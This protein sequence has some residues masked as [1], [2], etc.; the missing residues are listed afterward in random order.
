M[1][2]C[3]IFS[4][5]R[6]C[7]LDALLRSIK[8]NFKEIESANILYKAS[9]DFFNQGYE[10][11]KKRYKEF[12][13]IKEIE[14]TSDYKRIV[15]EYKKEFCLN[16][17]DDEIIINPYPIN[18]FLNGLS[19][20]QEIFHCST[21]RLHPQVNHTYTWNLD[22]PLKNIIRIKNLDDYFAY[23][24][25]SNDIRTEWGFPSCINSHIYRT[26]F[27]QLNIQNLNFRSVNEMEILFHFNQ[28]QNFKKLIMGYKEPKTISIANNK[29][30]EG[31]SRHSDK[32]EY[33]LEN[34]NKRF[35]DNYIIDVRKF[36]G[37]KWN[38]A[39]FESEYSFIKL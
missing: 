30:Q 14:F 17:V 23:D 37:L 22:S 38:E 10:E 35:L 28:R 5:D 7:Q 18:I 33:S 2:D 16:L 27:W 11:L 12:N 26:K 21:L 3:T 29:T 32:Q 1:L 8:D 31:V 36:Y 19:K 6:A 39:T 13:W 34:L 25:G 24:W 20:N 15:S 4:K 9:N